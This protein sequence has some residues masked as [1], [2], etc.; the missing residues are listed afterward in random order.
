MI[1]YILISAWSS[2]RYHES[3]MDKY[4]KTMQSA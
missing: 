2:L 3:Y 1:L 4:V